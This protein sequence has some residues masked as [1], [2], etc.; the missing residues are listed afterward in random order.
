MLEDILI[1]LIV[2]A[3]FA[4]G[5]A[6]YFGAKEEINWWNKRFQVQN[7]SKKFVPFLAGILGAIQAFASGTQNFEIISL[8]SMIA[9]IAFGSFAISDS[10]KNAAIKYTAEA[11]IAFLVLFAAVYLAKNFVI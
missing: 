2:A 9:A 1:A 7:P 4:I 10:N 5:Q 11:I 3:S 8:I 6:L